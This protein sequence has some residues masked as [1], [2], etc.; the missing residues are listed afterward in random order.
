MNTFRDMFVIMWQEYSFRLI[1]QNNNYE[2][3][4]GNICCQILG[5]YVLKKIKIK[6]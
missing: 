5:F 6:V 2:A 1:S 4:I 3:N